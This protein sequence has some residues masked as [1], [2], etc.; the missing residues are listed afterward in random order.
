MNLAAR[1]WHR[2]KYKFSQQQIIGI[3]YYYSKLVDKTFDEDQRAV[4]LDPST[5]VLAEQR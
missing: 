5:R 3:N 1:F 2:M 4:A